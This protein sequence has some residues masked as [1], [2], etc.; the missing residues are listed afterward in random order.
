MKKQIIVCRPMGGVNDCLNQISK[1]I[2]YALHYDRVIVLD[3]RVSSFPT[4]FLDY[5]KLD[6]DI[7]RIVYEIRQDSASHYAIYGISGSDNSYND[8]YG[9]KINAD[10]LDEK[11]SC[12][13]FNQ[14]YD[15]DVIVHQSFGGGIDSE[16]FLKISTLSCEMKSLLNKYQKIVCEAEVSI[17]IRNTD[18]STDW[19][20]VFRGVIK[21]F[22][23]EKIFL[24]TD[25]ALVYNNAIK[26]FG[27]RL[28]SLEIYRS[29]GASN[30]HYEN[31]LS[32]E[33]SILNTK[34]TIVD[35]CLL[36]SPK[37]LVTPLTKSYQL[38]GFSRLASLLGQD[39]IV[40]NKFT[41]M[42]RLF[43]GEGQVNVV[44]NDSYFGRKLYSI[45]K[46]LHTIKNNNS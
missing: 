23:I 29:D 27:D 17:H 44:P 10:L 30:I 40:Y 5:F 7:G 13:N 33:D 21:Q 20:T 42:H 25:S 26:L 11:E 39:S 46:L 12:L 24:A 1:S 22:P 28:L 32:H 34:R 19:S 9:A 16:Y 43:Q 4:P 14:T 45:K 2:K 15:E 35:L 37:Y 3:H 31:E 6:D 18:L 8:L 36:A 41:G 38:S